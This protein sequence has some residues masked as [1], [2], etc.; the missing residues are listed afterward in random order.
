[1]RSM[2]DAEPVSHA[3]GSAERRTPWAH[4]GVALLICAVGL[5]LLIG[6][7][8]LPEGLE[9]Q[10]VGPGVFPII[11][12]AGA[13][14]VGLVNV[15]QLR[16]SPV[17]ILDR[18]AEERATTHWPTAGLLAGTLA[19]YA[20]VFVP[21]GFWQ[22][23]TVLVTVVARILG[24]RKWWRDVLVGLALALAVYFLFDRALGVTLPP[25]MIRL[26]F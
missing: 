23:S 11:I 5:V 7:L 26:A 1:M 15:V 13:L 25:G 16:R 3:E 12:G 9:S 20:A 22:S 10:T 19:A 2:N 8:L 24:S 18:A 21:L 14:L 4:W 6:G 17:E